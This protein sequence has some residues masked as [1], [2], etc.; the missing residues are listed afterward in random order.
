MSA[1]QP[2]TP[3]VEYQIHPENTTM[4]QW[5]T[6]WEKRGQDAQTGEPETTAMYKTTGKGFLWRR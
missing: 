3:V 2:M 5:L 1:D 4:A 6:T